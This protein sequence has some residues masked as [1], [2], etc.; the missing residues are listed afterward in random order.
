VLIPVAAA[1]RAETKT[2]QF[3]QGFHRLVGDY[4]LPDCFGQVQNVLVVYSEEAF[5]PL[6][7]VQ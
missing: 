5:G 3:A 1:D 7:P 6:G 2:G 4:V